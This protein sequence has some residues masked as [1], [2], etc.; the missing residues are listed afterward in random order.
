[1]SFIQPMLNLYTFCGLY[2]FTC[3]Q[4]SLMSTHEHTSFIK[5]FEYFINI[6]MCCSVNVKCN[7][8]RISYNVAVLETCELYQLFSIQRYNTL[9]ENGHTFAFIFCRHTYRE[10]AF[11]FLEAIRCSGKKRYLNKVR[12][13]IASNN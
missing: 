12:H 8:R 9:M 4:L 13:F 6:H 5:I 10:Q 2:I 7:A 1:M 11:L 3:L